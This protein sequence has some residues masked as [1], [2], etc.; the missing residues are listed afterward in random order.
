MIAQ[1]TILEKKL[2]GTR[3]EEK[4]KAM[5]ESDKFEGIVACMPQDHKVVGTWLNA[6]VRWVELRHNTAA[7][8]VEAATSTLS[9]V[10]TCQPLSS[11]SGAV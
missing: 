11:S 2:E 6:R 5:M 10:G 3:Q 4:I 9:I 1:G 8:E 7:R